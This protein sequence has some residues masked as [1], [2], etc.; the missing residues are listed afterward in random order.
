MHSLRAGNY[1]NA[2]MMM[3][4]FLSIVFLTKM[5]GR[6]KNVE[7]EKAFFEEKSGLLADALREKE[8]LIREIYHR[9]KNH[10][11]TL[12]SLINLSHAADSD[13]L[14]SRLNARIQTFTLLYNKL[15]YTD[16]SA[17]KII[18]C[19]YIEDLI[20]LIIESFGMPPD[21]VD[22]TVTGGDIRA[23]TRSVSLLGMIINELVSNSIKHAFKGKQNETK[24]INVNCDLHENRLVITYSDNGPGFSYNDLGKTGGHLGVHI[25][26]SLS[27]QLGG[28]VDFDP[29]RPSEFTLVFQDAA[30]IIDQK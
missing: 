25:I 11:S 29:A 18:L 19:D 4:V 20:R 23:T 24:K 5:L 12:A 22:C 1:W 14:I 17:S 30:R 15:S 2:A 21:S 27:N 16:D 9:T 3:F 13:A 26:D 6:K 28:D 10:L 7:N 8:L